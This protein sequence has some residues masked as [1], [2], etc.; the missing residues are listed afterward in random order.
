MTLLGLNFEE[1]MLSSQHGPSR[2]SK[3]FDLPQHENVKNPINSNSIDK[4]KNKLSKKEVQVVETI[5]YKTSKNFNY[6]NF[7][8]SQYVLPRFQPKTS[9]VILR[10]K[11]RLL[12]LFFILPLNIRKSTFYLIDIRYLRSLAYVNLNKPTQKVL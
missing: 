7:K 3:L 8:Q 9:I 1:T 5:C 12:K 2:E 11:I 4:W 6:L 10:L